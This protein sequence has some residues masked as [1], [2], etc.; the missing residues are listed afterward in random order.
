MN[1]PLAISAAAILA[2]LTATEVCAVHMTGLYD[3]P[4][5]GEWE[6]EQNLSLNKEPARAWFASFADTDSALKILPENS[7]WWRSLDSK[8]DWAF[9]WS[10]DPNSRPKEFYRMDYD[11]SKWDRITVPCSWQAEG[12][13][14]EKGRYG[15]PIY[16]N[17]PYPFKRDWPFV[18]GEPPKSYTN[19]DARN[20][21]GSYRRD[22]D[23]PADW[24]GRQLYLQFDGVDSFF[25]LW[26]NGKYIGYSKD[27]RNPAAF[28]V[29]R[30][31]K[32]G[33]NTV[34]LEVY[35][36][37]DA[38][39]LE[40][41]DMFRL[42]G[43]FRSVS[44]YSLPNVHVR[45][46]FAVTEPVKEINGDWTVTVDAELS[47]L[48][49]REA[50]ANGYTL[51][52]RLYDADGRFVAPVKPSDPPWNGI[53][54]K[55]VDLTGQKS[56]KTGLLM[57]YAAPA[58][59][60][61]ET[62]SLYTLTL[63]V[64]HPAGILLEVVSA[65]L[66]F[67]KV[68]IKDGRFF[69]NGEKIKLKGVNRH[70]SDPM[71]G[72]TVSRERQEEDVRLLKEGNINHVRNSHYPTDSYFYYLCNKYGIYLQ[73]EA[74]IE[75]HGYYYG[76]ESLSHPVEWLD[77]HVDRIMNMVER[78]KNHPSIVIWSLGNEAGPGRN[79]LIAEKTIKARDLTRPTHYERNN[80]IVDMGSNQYPSV[81]W[82]QW[83]ATDSKATKPFYISEYAHNM[84]NALGNF[85]DYQEAIES[86][87]VILGGA[88]WDWVDQGL[89]MKNAA[90]TRILAYGGDFGDQPNSGQFV[91]NGTIL[92]DRTPEPGYHEVKHVYQNIK[93]TSPAKGRLLIRNKNYFRDLSGYDAQWALYEDGLSVASGPLTLPAVGPMKSAETAMP[94]QVTGCKMKPGAL[95]S[96]R[97]RF[98]LKK[99]EG[100]L[101]AGF[102]A[103][104]DDIA[105][106]NPAPAKP[107]FQ[108]KAGPLTKTEKGDTVTFTGADFSATFSRTLGTLVKYTC[109][110]VTL[111]DQPIV[112][113]ALRC[114][115][116]NEVG[117]SQQWFAQGLRVIEQKALDFTDPKA[118][119]NVFSFST[120]AKAAGKTLERL[121]RFGDTNTKIIPL[122]TKPT[123]LN[124]HFI[125]NAAWQVYPDGTIVCQSALLPRGRPIELGRL[126]YSF[127]LAKTFANLE[128][129]GAGPFENYA[130]RMSGA[131]I[132]RY[133]CKV[134][135]MVVAYG[136]PNDMGN[137]EATRWVAL[138][139]AAGI[140]LTLGALDKP[141]GFSALPYTATEL[142]ETM[143]PAELPEAKHTIL[144]LTA[145]SRGLGGASCGPGPLDRDIPRANIPYTLDFSIRPF[146]KGEP[147]LAP[148]TIRV[149]RVDVPKPMPPPPEKFTV[150]ECSSAEPGEGSAQNAVDGDP[151][152]LWHSQYGVTLGKY[153]HVLAFDT[154]RVR[155]L[156]GFTYLPRQGGGQNGKIKDYQIEVSLDLKTWEKAAKGA[157]DSSS[158]LQKVMFGRVI[159][160]RYVRIT[161]LSEINGQEFA[162]AA[163]FGIIEKR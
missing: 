25:Y 134:A 66:G 31:L 150:V 153:P 105:L 12:A 44:L 125:V 58:L 54:Q 98:T 71:T 154:A 109:R 6:Q 11:V 5:G 100:L 56:Y 162:S 111:I 129:F 94:A 102:E 138:S 3:A 48:L 18:M 52:A 28:N 149:P 33:R 77:A 62:P 126:G 141:F 101:K 152:T 110:G 14:P 144:T 8:T 158:S 120:S 106:E 55:T 13:N 91:F 40:C 30:F 87:D 72:H 128:Y 38:S 104:S 137:R 1:M 80:S 139:N 82:V 60:S 108:A 4:L 69:V 59:W 35:R 133:S 15:T 27:S 67:R 34:A 47:N 123:E 116:S 39:Y 41:Q 146:V 24:S 163:E 64:R 136:R 145:A 43:I 20:P 142:T 83:K 23:V 92:S 22:F 46:F 68:E 93:T 132:G 61:A 29:S 140:G 147:A 118:E 53:A 161:A 75:S 156:E 97:I 57:R 127:T 17:Q 26:V 2:A 81:G 157:F 50:D 130:D 84:M 99:D 70:E 49:P 51:E 151:S 63:E 143:H 155:Q 89:Y 90:G 36:N 107:L 122:E 16:C 42:S 114:P 121:D 7:R 119:N 148:D 86:S 131:F 76:K 115:S 113:D 73:D 95:Y 85:A 45:D 79:F 135:D 160:A 88:I 21:V 10:P 19:Y 124:T 96:L 103:A 65:Q 74:N 9:M 78:N 159:P 32:P 112:V 117:T 37:S